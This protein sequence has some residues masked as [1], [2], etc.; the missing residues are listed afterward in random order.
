[1]GTDK[2]FTQSSLLNPS[3]IVGSHCADLGLTRRR[4][5]LFVGMT[6]GVLSYCSVEAMFVT[7]EQ[8]S[9]QERIASR[10]KFL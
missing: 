9:R 10:R 6:I 7:P 5:K 4:N 1:M 2:S 8:T 3:D